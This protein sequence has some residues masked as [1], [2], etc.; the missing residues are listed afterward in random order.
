MTYEVILG[1]IAEKKAKDLVAKKT[2]DLDLASK[3]GDV[4]KK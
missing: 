2:K 4:T 3:N 1:K